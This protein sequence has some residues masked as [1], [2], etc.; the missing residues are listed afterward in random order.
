MPEIK[1]ILKDTDIKL[2]CRLLLSTISSMPLPRENKDVIYEIVNDI[3]KLENK[4]LKEEAK[5]EAE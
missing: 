4:R 3:V 2:Q 5:A 1:G